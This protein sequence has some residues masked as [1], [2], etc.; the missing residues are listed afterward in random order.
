MSRYSTSYD[1]GEQRA[2]SPRQALAY[3]V[4]AAALLFAIGSGI[5]AVMFLGA[6]R[7]SDEAVAAR[8]LAEGK[9]SEADRSE[10][11][12]RRLLAQ[13]AGARQLAETRADAAEQARQKA[14][15]ER[16]E[17]RRK[18]GD[19][20]KNARAADS[21]RLEAKEAERKAHTETQVADEQRKQEVERRRDTARQMVKLQVVQGSRLLDD[22][23]LPQALLWC[24]EALRTANRDRL[25]EDAHRLRLALALSQHPKLVQAWLSEPANAAQLSPDGRL[26]MLASLN[27]IRLWDATTGKQVGEALN[28][29][30]P[31]TFAAFTPD[32]KRIVSADSDPREGISHLHVRDAATG[33]PVFAPLETESAISNV[34]VSRDGKH[35]VTMSADRGGQANLRAYDADDGKVVGKGLDHAGNVVALTFSADG[36]EV[37]MV[38]TDRTLRRW[39]PVS[40]DTGGVTLD[41]PGQMLAASFSVDGTR[42]VTVGGAVARVWLAAT[43]RP[44]A[45]PLRHPGNV[46]S[47]Q[48]S[49][50]GRQVVTQM[51]TAARVW[52]AKSGEPI[53]EVLRHAAAITQA[54]FS[55]DG[56]YVLTATADG[57]LHLW[58]AGTGAEAL[59]IWQSGPVQTAQLSPDGGRLLTREGKAVRLWDLTS[60]EP[61]APAVAATP[62]DRSWFSPDGKLV[63]RGSENTV[64]LYTIEKNQPVGPPLKH[65]Y[66]V[67]DAAFSADGKRL[68]TVTNEPRDDGEGLVQVWDAGT[69]QPIGEPLQFVRPVSGVSFRGDGS[70]VLIVCA[71]FKVRVFDVASGQIVGKPLDHNPAVQRALFSP[72]GKLVATATADFMVR[73]WDVARGEQESKTLTHHAPLSQILF[74]RDSKRLLTADQKG[75]VCVWEAAS[76]DRIS[77]LP[78]LPGATTFASFNADGKRLVTV[79][80]SLVRVWD[81]DKG[82]PITPPIDPR[83]PLAATSADTPLAAFSPDG[84]WLATAA[85]NHFR[86]WDAMTGEPIGPSLGHASGPQTISQLTFTPDGKLV[87]GTGQ[88][89]DPRGRQVWDFLPDSRAVAEVQ[90]FVELLTGHRLQDMALT[91][92]TSEDAQ[93]AWTTLRPRYPADFAASPERARAWSRRGLEECERQQNWTG[94]VLH[95]DQ[96]I[97]AEP[98][99]PDLYLRRAAAYKALH[100]WDTALADYS[101]AI[102]QQKDR[103]DL[104][105]T[106]AAV[107]AEQRQWDKA[108]ADLTKAIELSA[109]DAELRANRGRAYAELGQW[110]RASADF[111]RA[112]ALGREEPTS[113][114]DQA[115]AR[116]GAGDLAGYKQICSRMAKRFGGSQ[117]AAQALGWTCALVPDALPDLKPLVQHAERALASNTESMPHHLTVALLLYRTGQ[118]QP[119]LKQLEKVQELRTPSHP[120]FDWVLLAMTQQRLS[121]GP[122]AKEWLGK[123]AGSQGGAAPW[124]WQERLALSVL[125]K[126]AEGLLKEKKP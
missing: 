39:N 46:L 4:G 2:P 100:Q 22:G 3:V 122:E 44:A 45:P 75:V 34:I 41:H 15:R 90:E 26:V 48:F 105:S 96:L 5:L 113:F 88:A 14:Q 17:D 10:Q 24:T 70:Q 101:K 43:G 106:R 63:L 1:S 73:V 110:D 97:A 125:R 51:A 121:R 6:R 31:I 77:Q 21:Q 83:D 91:S 102:D 87:T 20:E 112:I 115:L 116:L 104:W 71:D 74:S 69:G 32:G 57:R 42:V 54:A 67:A 28:H 58:H 119:A 29:E 11:E 78:D 84:H 16:D 118:L 18:A 72:D 111:G 52:D 126:E 36:R 12:S 92:L 25:P 13:E 50:D 53:G 9:Q 94:A 49:R 59:R 65:K 103:P 124:T 37:L 123:A 60:A 89:G 117:A 79:C 109:N 81:T 120:P 19:A 7:D 56:R 30:L 35:L 99:R 68:A 93:K 38:G 40:G 76:G 108:A 114:A 86:L 107:Y 23:D 66:A 62:G 64:Q 47:A 82:T 27:A 33:K 55:P 95:L 98:G 61:A 8:V 85:G 80:Q